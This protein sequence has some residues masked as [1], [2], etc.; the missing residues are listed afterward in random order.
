M[1]KEEHNKMA[2]VENLIWEIAEILEPNSLIDTKKI[3]KAKENLLK[4]FRE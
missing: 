4:I 2:K 1:S 3:K